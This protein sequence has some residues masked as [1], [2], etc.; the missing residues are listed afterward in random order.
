MKEPAKAEMKWQIA[1]LQAELTERRGI[2]DQMSILCLG[3]SQ[4]R[5]DAYKEIG[6]DLHKQWGA[7]ERY[8][9]KIMSSTNS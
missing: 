2:G 7:I 1:K 4:R 6:H 3:L 5:A 9:L 8:Q